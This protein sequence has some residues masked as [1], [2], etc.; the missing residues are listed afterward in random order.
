MSSLSSTLLLF[1][2]LASVQVA[3][4]SDAKSFERSR[5]AIF[6]SISYGLDV[7]S[8][9]FGELPGVEDCCVTYDDGSGGAIQARLGYLLPID[10]S[11]ELGLSLGVEMSNTTFEER[12][13]LGWL[14]FEEETI[15][16]YS[17][18]TLETSRFTLELAGNVSIRPLPI[19]LSFTAGAG[20]DIANGM[21]ATTN[22]ELNAPDQV[23]FENFD[24][25]RNVQDTDVE[26]VNGF[27]PFVTAG[28]GYDILNDE[29]SPIRLG[30]FTQFKL[31]LGDFAAETDWTAS[32]I[33]GGL[34]A[35]Y[36]FNAIAP[37]APE[38]EP[39][40][41]PE[42]EPVVVDTVPPVLTLGQEMYHG[43]ERVLPAS[44]FTLT[45]H[46]TVEL[47][48]LPSIPSMAFYA[49][50]ETAAPTIGVG[51]PKMVRGW[52]T[53]DEST[54]TAKKRAQQMAATLPNP[55]SIAIADTTVQ[56][57]NLSHPERADEFRRVDVLST[58]NR[59]ALVERLDDMSVHTTSDSVVISSMPVFHVEASPFTFSGVS[60]LNGRKF[61]ELPDRPRQVSVAASQLR[62]EE[63]LLTFEYTITDS[64]KR[65]VST[66]E[67]VLLRR[68][69]NRDTVYVSE[70]YRGVVPDT[71]VVALFDFDSS[72]PL[73]INEDFSEWIR[74]CRAQGHSIELIGLTD[75]FGS[76]EHNR[77]LAEQRLASVVNTFSLGSGVTTS[78]RTTPLYSDK[79]PQTRMLNRS[80][81]AVVV[82]NN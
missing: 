15:A 2:G 63:N 59:L 34:Q 32:T 22:E 4:A 40:P 10:E 61:A 69:I 14:N 5:N 76:A 44:Q 39:I 37:P 72:S 38:P 27:I 31:R 47:K 23:V 21:S 77:V 70:S 65:T 79:Q 57:G 64:T 62:D 43:Q 25:V 8:S 20:I 16:T 73:C 80:V 48:V 42:P 9:S 52:Q 33:G 41:E 58:N 82:K 60:R 36:Y 24:R 75:S 53:S 68:N 71:L 50:N 18:H 49:V 35:T 12:E 1:V 46:E 74:S 55:E 26:D 7:H 6:G 56:I 45:R 19:P 51:S 54:G 13:F 3:V 29:S 66:T 30:I 81:I 28:V 78:V 67:A 17:D 11:V